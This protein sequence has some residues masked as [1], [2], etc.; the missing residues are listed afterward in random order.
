MAEN[1]SQSIISHYPVFTLSVITVCVISYLSPATTLMF[2]FDR[3]GIMNGEVWRLFTSHFVHFT[4]MQL[5]YNLLVFVVAGWIV[6]KKSPLHF[7]FLYVL[8]ALIT[9]TGLFILEP[10]MTN[11]GGLSGLAC[12][13]M[14]YG[15]LLGLEAS[16]SWRTI[17]IL[18]ILFL[19]I[20]ILIESYRHGSI[21]PYWGQQ[22]FVIMPISHLLGII[23][24]LSYYAIL[25]A[26]NL[27]RFKMYKFYHRLS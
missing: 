26:G 2:I 4:R 3:I 14:F 1:K 10:E 5:L 25:K 13:F 19:P 22:S 20:K 6:E 12:G 18:I 23:V 17:S 24:A 7:G 9:G 8:M 27:H 11:Y 16:K 15:A 21:L